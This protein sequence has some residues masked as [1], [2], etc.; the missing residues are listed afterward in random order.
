MLNS[1]KSN[2]K[3]SNHKNSNYGSNHKGIECSTPKF[4]IN[5]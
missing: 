2:G 5:H 1:I 4:I 3:N